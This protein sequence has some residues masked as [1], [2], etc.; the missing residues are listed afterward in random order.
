MHTAQLPARNPSG[1]GA[2]QRLRSNS[3]TRLFPAVSYVATSI[4]RLV[5]LEVRAIDALGGLGFLAAFWRWTIIAVLGME[6][7]I[8]VAAEFV[9]AMKPRARANENLAV[10]PFRAVVAGRS[11]IIRSDVIVTVRTIRSRANDDADLSFCFGGGSRDTECSN[12][13]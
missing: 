4:T 12:S 11:T 7:V 10:K 1:P 5:P 2:G 3:P 6:T 8:H 13:S 9:V